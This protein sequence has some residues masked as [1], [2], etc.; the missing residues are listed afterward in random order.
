M[1]TKLCRCGD[2]SKAG[3]VKSSVEEEDGLEYADVELSGSG[4]SYQDAPLQT[5]HDEM[6]PLQVITTDERTRLI[7]LPP[8]PESENDMVIAPLDPGMESLGGIGSGEAEVPEDGPNDAPPPYVI[9]R[10]L[11]TRSKGVIKSKPLHPHPY[12]YHWFKG[13]RRGVPSVEELRSKVLRARRTGTPS[14]RGGSYLGD[15]ESSSSGA[16]DR[17]HCCTDNSIVLG[18]GDDQ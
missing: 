17:V 11:C 10:Q 8:S 18:S 3:S 12:A 9:S 7:P 15:D 16:D 1:T 4:S 2:T 5:V 14:R 13:Q 6:V